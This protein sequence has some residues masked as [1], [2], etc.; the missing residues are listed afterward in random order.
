MMRSAISAP[1]ASL[2]ILLRIRL[3][4]KPTNEFFDRT[5]V[6][7]PA[8]MGEAWIRIRKNASYFRVNYAIIIVSTM[9][10]S[11][12]ASLLE[13]YGLLAFPKSMA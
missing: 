1:Y 8:S 4:R 7:K 6:D 10:L 13:C 12:Y 2:V 9:C 5:A 3:Q 11:L